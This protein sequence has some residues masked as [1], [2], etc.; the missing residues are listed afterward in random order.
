[1]QVAADALA[2]PGRAHGQVGQGERAARMLGDDGLGQRRGQLPPPGRRGP[3]RQAKRVA[4][5]IATV[6]RLG[7]RESR[8]AALGPVAGC[9][10]A[11]VWPVHLG[12]Q[13]QQVSRGRR[14]L[15]PVQQ[16]Q[17]DPGHGSP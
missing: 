15:R 2:P 14:R 5:Q 12:A 10:S 6:A 9:E 4:D 13:L 8:L 1:M 7:Q 11:V 16:L 3:Q 17:R